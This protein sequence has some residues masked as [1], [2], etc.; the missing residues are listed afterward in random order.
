[1]RRLE[2]NRGN[3]QLSKWLHPKNSGSTRPARQ[4]P[5]I[6]FDPASELRPEEML[7]R[8]RMNSITKNGLIEGL[9]AP[10]SHKALLRPYFPGGVVLGRGTLKFL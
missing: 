7:R 9:Q 5:C 10:S 1:M 4:L 2:T 6:G 8:F 3:V